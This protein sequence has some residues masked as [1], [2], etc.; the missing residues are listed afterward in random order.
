MIKWK[1]ERVEWYARRM[2]IINKPE[3]IQSS[4]IGFHKP[5]EHSHLLG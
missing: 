3:I 1:M 4:E 5:L 2:N